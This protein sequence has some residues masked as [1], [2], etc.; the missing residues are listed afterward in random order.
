MTTMISAFLLIFIVSAVSAET[1]HQAYEMPAFADNNIPQKSGTHLNGPGD[2]YRYTFFLHDK[3]AKNHNYRITKATFGVH[4]LDS[5]Y[6]K[7]TGDDIPEW[8]KITMDGKERKWITLPF[9]GKNYKLGKTPSLSTV[10]EI[11]SDM[12][13]GGLPPYIYDVTDLIQDHKLIID[14]TNVRK[15]GKIYSDAP[16]GDFQVLRVGL[17]VWWEKME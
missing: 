3:Y 14:I 8:G 15:D 13:N 10:Y 11:E 4:I 12:E 7:L 2:N 5:D 6:S 1:I 17:H 16:F 9:L